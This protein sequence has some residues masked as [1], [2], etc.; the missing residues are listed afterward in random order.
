MFAKDIIEVGADGLIFEPVNDFGYMA[1]NFG[2]T[3]CLV[4]SYVDCKDMTFE[5]WDK[6]KNDIDRT[7]IY[8]KNGKCKGLI[9]A[10]GNH[11]PGNVSDQICEKYIN[12]LLARSAIVQ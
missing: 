7:L 8:V 10:V 12:Y 11:I 9:F 6:V 5:K 1:E 4:G 2:D 3:V